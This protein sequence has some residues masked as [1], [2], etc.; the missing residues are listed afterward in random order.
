M[1]TGN[2]HSELRQFLRLAVP[3]ASAQLAQ[4]ATGFIDTLMMG[5]LGTATLAAGGLAATTFMAV[6]VMGIGLVLGITPVVAAAKGSGDREQVSRWSQQGFWL[7]LLV[8]IPMMLLTA[9]LPSLML[10][11]GQQPEVV[12]ISR[13]Y[14]QI[15]VWGVWPALFFAMFKSVLSAVANPRMITVI[16][17]GGLVLN[18]LGNYVLAFGKLGFPAMGLA[19]LAIATVASHWFMALTAV[20]YA[21]I[22]RRADRLLVWP[23][24]PDVGLLGKLLQLGWPLSVSFGLEVGLFTIITYLMGTFGTAALAA[25]QIVFQTISLMF[26]VPLGMS[27][28]T[29]VRVGEYFGQGDSVGVRRATHLAM[30]TSLVFTAL[31]SGWMLLF[32]RQV[33]GLYLD[34]ANPENADT[35]A[36]GV[37]LMRIAAIAQLADGLQ[38]V[39]AGGLRGLQDTR[40]PMLLGFVAFWVVGLQAGYWLGIVG[41]WGPIGL[42]IG[43]STGVL[44][45]S[46]L[47]YGQ[48]Y[49]R[50]YKL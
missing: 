41:R 37:T 16:V 10:V 22:W 23:L 12:S 3:L 20:G 8:A 7:S 30:K 49:R 50:S 48:F 17:I 40:T 24:I 42:W 14:L 21:L 33:M 13:I 44:A 26:M 9:L 31:V 18:G 11:L 27:I 28:A 47:F 25:H 5:W 6:L 45:A 38:T 46:L 29:T 15:L 43:Q 34:L 39:I 19:G 36:I 32:P 2:I 1:T 4:A 35:I